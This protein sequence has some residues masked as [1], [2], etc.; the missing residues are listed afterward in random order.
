MC[1]VLFFNLCTATKFCFELFGGAGVRGWWWWWWGRSVE[2]LRLL[3]LHLSSVTCLLLPVS[4]LRSTPKPSVHYPAC[5]NY[6]MNKA[7]NNPHALAPRS[8]RPSKPFSVTPH[9]LLY[10]AL[11]APPVVTPVVVFISHLHCLSR[12]RYVALTFSPLSV[13]LWDV[14]LK[15][16]P[17]RHCSGLGLGWQVRYS[18]FHVD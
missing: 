8:G 5:W 15:I 12:L 6:I 18:I 17:M 2:S 3:C 16:C 14:E 1:F 7:A 11:P 9:N 4:A 10:R 13:Q